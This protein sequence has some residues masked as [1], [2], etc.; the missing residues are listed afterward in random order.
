MTELLHPDDLIRRLKL[1]RYRCFIITG[2]PGTGKSRLARAMAARTGGQYLDLMATFAADV[3]L[4]ANLDTF[5]PRRFKDWLR[6]YYGPTLVLLDE[7]EFLWHRWDDAEK[8]EFLTILA[9]MPKA[10][11]F[12]AFLPPHPLIENFEMLDQDGRP[13]IFA[14][15]EMKSVDS[16][17][18]DGSR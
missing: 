5:T 16:R 1:N 4:A 6:P 10:A 11:F 9:R 18:V 17:T 3:Q 13:R 14:L 2:R 7:M 12:G 15:R 8:Q